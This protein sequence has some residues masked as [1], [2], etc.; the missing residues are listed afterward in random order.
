M[1]IGESGC[2]KS[3]L[4]KMLI[5]EISDYTGDI[6]L[7]DINYRDIL[8]NDLNN[9]VS[10][11]QQEVYIFDGTIRNNITMYKSYSDEDVEDAIEK[12]GFKKVLESKKIDLETEL[13]DNGVIFSG[14]EK[15]R[16]ALARAIVNKKKIMI[17]DEPL[18]ALDKKTG[19]DV[20]K[21]ITDLS[22]VII[23]VVLHQIDD[24][25]KMLFD[26]VLKLS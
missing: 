2:G 6:Y 9:F 18:S 20:L 25:Y 7:D 13:K 1:V 15:Q 10:Y 3:T 22:D 11:S 21:S 26:Q 16:L 5:K 8:K 12:S 17:F 19:Y 4:C 24:D 23:I 14:G